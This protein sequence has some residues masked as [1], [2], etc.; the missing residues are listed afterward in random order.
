M[1]LLK[2]AFLPCGGLWKT[3]NTG[4][5]WDLLFDEMPTMSI[6]AL[7]IPGTAPNTVWAGT[8]TLAGGV[9]GVRGVLRAPLRCVEHLAGM[10]LIPTMAA[11]RMR[12]IPGPMRTD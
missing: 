5:T 12:A 9:R 4:V 3:T 2:R 1:K 11:R 8:G 7:A 6:G 10:A